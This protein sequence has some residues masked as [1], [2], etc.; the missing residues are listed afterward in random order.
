MTIR[1]YDIHANGLYEEYSGSDIDLAIYDLNGQG[2]I[3][4]VFKQKFDSITDNTSSIRIFG[5]NKI[6]KVICNW[7]HPHLLRDISKLEVET[8][9]GAIL[10]HIVRAKNIKKILYV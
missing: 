2:Y 6:G 10:E 3:G 5:S 8:K 4:I 9:F 7:E 1:I